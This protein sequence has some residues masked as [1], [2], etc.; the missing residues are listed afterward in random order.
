MWV[1]AF[2]AFDE[3]GEL[4]GQGA[5]LAAVLPRFG[6]QG[7]EAAGAIAKRP[8]QQRIDGNGNAFGIGD[9]V[10][11]GGN[12]LGAAG[13]FSAGQS[14]EHQRSH[15]AVSK[16]GEFFSFGVHDRTIRGTRGW[17][18]ANVMW[19]ASGEWLRGP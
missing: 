12:L 15:E 7:L 3:A 1:F 10:V 14:F 18:D 9:G 8:I 13:E 17:R 11:T 4:W 5:R 19:G 16:Q 2:E 6:R